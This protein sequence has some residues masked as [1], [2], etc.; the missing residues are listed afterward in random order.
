MKLSLKALRGNIPQQTIADYLGITRQAYSNYENGNRNP[1][2]ETLLKLADYFGVSVDTLFR[3]TPSQT[4][5]P[6]TA[7]DSLVPRNDEERTF[8]RLL[9]ES[10]EVHRRLAAG[11]LQA[12]TVNT[13][14]VS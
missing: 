7:P 6:L 13:R 1:D 12:S 2:N 10:D 8:I 3:G 5:P 9:R 11:I 4:N 14:P